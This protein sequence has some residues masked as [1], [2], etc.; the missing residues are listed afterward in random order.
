MNMN[1]A[2]L[3]QAN[4]NPDQITNPTDGQITPELISTLTSRLEQQAA[5]ITQ[6]NERNQA[7]ET[8][9]AN[10]RNEQN[11]SSLAEAA[12]L[13]KI[14]DQEANAISQNGQSQD[15]LDQL[16]NRQLF[17]VLSDAIE[18]SMESKIQMFDNKLK[19]SSKPQQDQMSQITQALGSVLAKLD[20]NDVKGK[21]ED[22]GKYGPGV[23]ETL[24]QY[25]GMTMEDAYIL[26]KSKE[27][28]G[29][30][31]MNIA[32]TERPDNTASMGVNPGQ[33]VEQRG[34]EN[35]NAV[36]SKGG[37]MSFRELA[38]EAAEQ[39]LSQGQQ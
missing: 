14:L 35:R 17:D 32:A 13:K 25:P 5:I 21:Y 33:K 38:R 20:V 29:N 24:K 1:A 34:Q 11:N 10:I 37:S 27:A 18:K 19:E 39:L 3:N 4:Q 9:L 23:A 28:Q 7:F 22:F 15:A 8:E 36:G 16:S 31:P 26:T 6:L 2:Q 12:D 30:P